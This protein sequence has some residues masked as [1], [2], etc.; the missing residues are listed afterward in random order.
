VPPQLVGQ[1]I[2]VHAND[3]AVAIFLGPKQVAVHRRSWDIGQDIEHP[4]HREP[5]PAKKPRA[6]VGVLPLG[7]A[8]LGEVGVNY[9]KVV[10]AGTRYMHWEIVRLTFLVELFGASATTTAVDEVMSTGHVGA[11]TWSTCCGTSAAWSRRPRPYGSTTPRS[12]KSP[13]PSP[14]S[15]AMTASPSGHAIPASHRH[16]AAS[17]R[18]WNAVKSDYVIALLV[19][20]PRWLRLPRMA[21]ALPARSIQPSGWIRPKWWQSDVTS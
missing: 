18:R 16:R 5:A 9:F 19:E 17:R 11:D 1:T 8:G 14:I 15:P 2:L 10:A 7:L 20:K 12:T 6:A 3:D 13:S 4:A 21:Q